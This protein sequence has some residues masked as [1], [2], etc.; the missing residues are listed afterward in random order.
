VEIKLFKKKA[1]QQMELIDCDEDKSA[2]SHSLI[3]IIIHYFRSF[4]ML[5][6]AAK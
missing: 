2:Q 5:I 4:F 6:F 3:F 1:L